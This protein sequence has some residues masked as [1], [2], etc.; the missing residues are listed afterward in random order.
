MKKG[1]AL[2][3][4]VWLSAV[5]D[6]Q[7][8]PNAAA[9]PDVDPARVDEAIRKGVAWLK[10]SAKSPGY[11]KNVNCDELLLL[12]LLHAG[13]SEDDPKVKELVDRVLV[14]KL[15]RTYNVSLLAVALEE[16]DRVKYQG[17]IAQCAQFLVDNQCQSGQWS[18]GT[19]SPFAVPVE[20][21]VRKAV[22][23]G[24]GK[25][26]GPGAKPEVFRKKP[27]VQTFIKVEKKREAEA[28]GDN[29][30]SQYAALGIR[31]CHD[32]GIVFPRSVLERALDGWKKLQIQDPKAV[33]E[34]VMVGGDPVKD[35]LQRQGVSKGQPSKTLYRFSAKPQ[36]WGYDRQY[37]ASP[38]GSMT[39]GA[40]A[41]VCIYYYCLDND[42]GRRQSWR[43]AR[44]VLEGIQWM[45]KKFSVDY[46]P[47][48]YAG[49]AD[50]TDKRVRFFYYLYALER[51]GML[52]GTEWIGPNKWY[53]IGANQILSEQHPDGSWHQTPLPDD[54]GTREWDTCW[55]ILFLKRATRPLTDVATVDRPK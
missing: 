20:T 28:S 26:P 35:M 8:K 6:A 55:A 12:T 53:P 29:S 11:G 22:A 15:E 21:P 27:A 48:T 4:L 31:A 19:P 41:S 51:V 52:Y 33:A 37:S 9:P 3:V 45:S 34:P 32:A 10:T 54:E 44:E 30:N 18:Y 36:G 50:W 24:E 2:V 46:N 38:W 42:G 47:G 7:Q 40:V 23:S 43:T 5:A 49:I 39:A 13:L 1:L 17:R 14:C 16:L 25:P